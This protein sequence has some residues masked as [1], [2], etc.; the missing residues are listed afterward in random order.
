MPRPQS[1][2]SIRE[3]VFAED[4][5]SYRSTPS[6]SIQRSRDRCYRGTV[7]CDADH[8]TRLRAIYERPPSPIMQRPPSPSLPPR[9]PSASPSVQRQISPCIQRVPPPPSVHTHEYSTG[10]F[11][12]SILANRARIRA[13][14]QLI[15]GAPSP[16]AMERLVERSPNRSPPPTRRAVGPIGQALPVGPNDWHHRL[17]VGFAGVQH[18][19]QHRDLPAIRKK[20]QQLSPQPSG[21]E[22]EST[23]VTKAELRRKVP[24]LVASPPLR[25]LTRMGRQPPTA[26][27]LPLT[28]G[29]SHVYPTLTL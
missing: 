25:S 23:P 2:A 14:S 15:T 27:S 26:Y 20:A 28:R 21:A 7:F 3:P 10:S 22:G 4:A 12:A 16:G 24:L 6:P 9:P 11:H 8:L 17:P 13:A 5:F 18:S 29:L 19:V 1:R